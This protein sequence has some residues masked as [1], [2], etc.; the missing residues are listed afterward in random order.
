MQSRL[1]S[2]IEAWAG[3][4]IGFVVSLVLSYIVYPMFG[5]TFTFMEN[6][7]IVLIFT[8]ASVIRGYVVRRVFN[9]V[10]LRTSRV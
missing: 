10:H 9:R 4:A 7:W 5:H 3:T 1:F 8:V 6:V 2:F